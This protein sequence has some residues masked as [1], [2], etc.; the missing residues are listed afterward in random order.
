M[1]I[2][3]LAMVVAEEKDIFND[4]FVMCK[5][6]ERGEHELTCSIEGTQLN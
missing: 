1:E 2:I 4:E 6:L 3:F 5:T